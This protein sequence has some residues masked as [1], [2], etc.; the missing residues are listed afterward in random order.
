MAPQR[1]PLPSVPQHACYLCG[2][3]SRTTLDKAYYGKTKRLCDRCTVQ[4]DKN[5]GYT[6]DTG[7]G[8]QKSLV[9]RSIAPASA[10]APAINPLS[11]TM[12]TDQ[13]GTISTGSNAQQG[14]LIAVSGYS[15]NPVNYANPDS[16]Q[17]P[18]HYQQ[19]P[20]YP[21]APSTYNDEHGILKNGT[22]MLMG[23]NNTTKMPNGETHVWST[24]AINGIPC[25]ATRSLMVFDAQG[26][27]IYPTKGV[28]LHARTFENALKT[29]Q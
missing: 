22:Y 6:A 15:N 23:L 27:L 2:I 8:Q 1:T 7:Y 3:K 12:V 26:K 5:F 20:S 19:P 10:S 16:R 4:S 14:A 17:Q 28:W 24:K 11:Q 9:A 29:K 18:L 25:E 13:S 21:P